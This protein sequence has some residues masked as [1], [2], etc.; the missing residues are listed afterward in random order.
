MD[1]D[2]LVYE[3]SFEDLL[4]TN[5]PAQSKMTIEE[6]CTTKPSSYLERTD[7]QYK[8]KQITT[9]IK[10]RSKCISQIESG[11]TLLLYGALKAQ[12]N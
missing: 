10:F 2:G 11:M 8:L 1:R 7:G 4:E 12:R 9:I 5:C 6:L 3:P